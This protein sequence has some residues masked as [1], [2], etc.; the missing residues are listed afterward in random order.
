MEKRD[1]K[2]YASY[3]PMRWE[4]QKTFQFLEQLVPG[5]GDD[6]YFSKFYHRYRMKAY[7]G[8]SQTMRIFE[9]TKGKY[10]EIPLGIWM[11]LSDCDKSKLS[12]E[13]WDWIKEV[14]LK[15]G[16]SKNMR[17]KQSNCKSSDLEI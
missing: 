17:I 3:L 4:H 16:K 6:V 13:T 2:K 7:Y 5:Y 12:K 11:E 10:R 15:Y 8:E 1:M 14:R 9:K